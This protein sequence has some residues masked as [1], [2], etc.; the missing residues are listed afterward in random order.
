MST[1]Q[2]EPEMK[3]ISV[4]YNLLTNKYFFSLGIIS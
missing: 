2:A 3:N 1:M 4:L